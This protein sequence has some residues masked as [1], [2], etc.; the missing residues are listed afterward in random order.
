[1]KRQLSKK[2]R[3]LPLSKKR[4]ICQIQL[5][6]HNFILPNTK[7]S[8]QQASV[9]T[10]LLASGYFRGIPT[11]ENSIIESIN[12]LCANY[13]LYVDYFQGA[14]VFAQSLLKDGYNKIEPDAME[15]W[16][17]RKHKKLPDD[18]YE[19]MVWSNWEC[20]LNKK[21]NYVVTWD[22]DIYFKEEFYLGFGHSELGHVCYELVM[23]ESDT[24]GTK[25]RTWVDIWDFLDC[26]RA[27]KNDEYL[28]A[29]GK[30]FE[31]INIV[32]Q[33]DGATHEFTFILDKKH[34]YKFRRDA[35]IT[36]LLYF[37]AN[38]VNSKVVLNS[39][40]FKF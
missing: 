7:S 22:M 37:A 35:D 17:K 24:I 28:M 5:S 18:F 23:S 26:R 16:N 2:E 13:I 38:S 25:I 40:N 34:I 39:F 12:H 6:K 36:V 11:S 1:M 10:F 19:R 9:S 32:V 30:I 20:H 33:F 31:S 21:E 29:I 14:T 27:Y 8:H 15:L 4:K 3:D